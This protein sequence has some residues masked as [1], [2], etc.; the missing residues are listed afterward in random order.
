MER[1]AR[2]ICAALLI[3]GLNTTA[4]ADE[5]PWAGVF[6]NDEQSDA[7]IQKAIEAATA[8]MNFI[9]RPIARSRLKK[10][11]TLAHRITITSQAETIT[12]RFDERKPAEMPAD[13]KVVKWTGEDGEQFDVFARTENGRLVQT[14]KAEDG[15]RVNS[16]TA[17]DA[18]RLTL[19]VQVTSPRLPKPLTYT[20]HY[21]RAAEK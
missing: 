13:G 4:R 12:V 8:D 16:F 21:K 3:L 20:V 18:Q 15:Q 7:G 10:T 9:T 14:F 5:S 6:V 11:N 1:S 19:E 17:E 2:Y